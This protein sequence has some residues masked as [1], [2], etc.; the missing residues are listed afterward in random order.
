MINLHQTFEPLFVDYCVYFNGNA[1]YFE[2]HEVLEELWK[3]V[4]P[5][6]KEHVLV[7]LIQVATGL[8][9]WRRENF[10]GAL[11]AL[12][13]AKQLLQHA[14]AAHEFK[15]IAL[16]PLLQQVTTSIHAVEQQASFT[17]F[18]LQ[19]NDDT[20]IQQVTAKIAALPEM[21]VHFIQHKHT[22]RD[23]SDVIALR[24]QRLH[25]KSNSQ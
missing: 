13:N 3:E 10:R 20:F 7:G 17:P 12:R 16:E 23:R 24:Q 6:D 14:H 15:F 22:L 11:K 25:E 9:H 8:Y 18:T 19:L 1:D 2:C 5:G 4:A 21:D